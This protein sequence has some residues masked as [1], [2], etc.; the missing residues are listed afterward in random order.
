MDNKK[1]VSIYEEELKLF[2]E[3]YDVELMEGERLRTLI[4]EFV[5]RNDLESQFADFLRE[6]KQEQDSSSGDI[7]Y[8]DI[9]HM[10]LDYVE[11]ESVIDDSIARAER[12]IQEQKE[13]A[14]CE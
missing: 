8:G 5:T 9:D 13:A 12:W 4:H 11:D 14:H 10:L 2:A 3:K 1:I 7:Y 6:L